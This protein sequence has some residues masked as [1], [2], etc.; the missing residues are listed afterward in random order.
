MTCAPSEDSDQP[1]H[2]PSLIRVF[3]VRM[4]K[5]WVLTCSYHLRGQRRLWSDW[6]DA[7]AD[8]SLR[9]AQSFCWFCHEAAQILPVLQLPVGQVIVIEYFN[10]MVY[11]SPQEVQQM[12]IVMSPSC[13]HL[14]FGH[15]GLSAPTLGICL[16]FFTSITADFNISS[17]LRWAIQDQWS[18]GFKS[19]VMSQSYHNIPH[20]VGR[21]LF[22]EI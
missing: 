1:G 14:N 2:L 20:L 15:N 11:K 7:Q 5:A 10:D 12:T 16:N 17:A 22:S 21:R 18:S 19:S 4:K 3:A 8:L 6:A 9:W 13:W